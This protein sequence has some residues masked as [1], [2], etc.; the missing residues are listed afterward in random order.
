MLLAAFLGGCTCPDRASRPAPDQAVN[1][2]ADEDDPANRP[3]SLEPPPRE[4]GPPLAETEEQI[5]AA[6]KEARDLVRALLEG[7]ISPRE[8]T[9]MADIR[10]YRLFRRRLFGQARAWFEA[11]VRT[12]PRFEPVLFNAAR[13]AAAHGDLAA[14]RAHLERLRRLDTPLARSRL[15][16][17]ATDPDLAKLTSR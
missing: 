12:D 5:A 6:E 9:S 2:P 11:A 7:G 3:S 8:V 15:R 4:P 13:A 17:A 16:L 14:A 10:G 1:T